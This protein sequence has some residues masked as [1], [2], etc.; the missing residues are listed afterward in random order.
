MTLTG[1]AAVFEAG[2]ANRDPDV[3]IGA[4]HHTKVPYVRARFR[5]AGISI[6]VG[7]F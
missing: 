1:C 2:C 6:T 5:K 4:P 7:S 3:A